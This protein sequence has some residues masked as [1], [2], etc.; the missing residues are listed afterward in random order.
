MKNKLILLTLAIGF[1]NIAM[2]GCNANKVE[3]LPENQVEINIDENKKD[4][5]ISKFIPNGKYNVVFKG[6]DMANELISIKGDGT[7]YQTIGLNGNGYYYEVFKVVNNQLLFVD[8]ED[9]TDIDNVSDKNIK[10]NED[11][12]NYEVV[13]KS[14]TDKKDTFQV[15]EIG[16]NLKLD[17]IELKGGYIKTTKNISTSDSKTILETYY[18]EGLGVVKYEVIMDG[19]VMEYSELISYEEIK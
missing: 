9:L 17:N 11:L 16:T 14:K 19:T 15:S 3:S 13:L 18:S 12:E 10:T 1:A 4:I 8:S 6:S 5:N 2:V 7:T